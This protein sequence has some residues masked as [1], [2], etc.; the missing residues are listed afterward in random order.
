MI[1]E[2]L[3]L[4]K[5]KLTG[6]GVEN[7]GLDSEVLAAFSLGIDR[8]GLFARLRDEAGQTFRE[9]VLALV[10][11]RAG[12]EPLQYI[13]GRQEFYGLMFRVSP[14][15][16]IPRPE[17]ELLVEQAIARL[18]DTVGAKAADIGTGSGCIAVA[19]AANLPGAR[20]YAVD[21]SEAALSIAEN[22]ALSNGVGGRISFLTGNLLAPLDAEGLASGLD[23]IASN[24][25]YIPSGDIPNLQPEVQKEPISA[26][27]GG[28][29]GLDAIR[30][31]VRDAPE[32]LRPGGTLLVEIGFGQ[33][34]AVKRLVESQP[35]LK[36]Q[37]LIKDF[38]GIERVLVARKI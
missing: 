17:T 24:P 20:V 38:A 30:D 22:N 8:A 9:E 11:R 23:L 2:L 12:R 29:D 28:P 18:K 37:K 25:P 36:F 3:A 15:V 4:G 14:A 10:E 31:I 35:G 34:D 33:G 26:L 5:E 32:C 1:A 27:D 13:T 16:L 6:A 7:P 21:S 19:L